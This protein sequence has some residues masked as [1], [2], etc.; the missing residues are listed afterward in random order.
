LNADDTDRSEAR[1][2]LKEWVEH[3]KAELGDNHDFVHTAL[4]II[5]SRMND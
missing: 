2:H 1:Q 3:L 5:H 4:D